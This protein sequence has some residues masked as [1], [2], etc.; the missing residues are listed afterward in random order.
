M[1][2]PEAAFINGT[3]LVIDGGI[4]V[5]PRNSWDPDSPS[6]IRVAIQSAVNP[7]GGTY[8]NPH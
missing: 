1:A 7:A 3:H 8:T 2:V 6:A 5:G 4:T